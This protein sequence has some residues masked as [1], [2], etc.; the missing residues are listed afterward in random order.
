MA[1]RKELDVAV[2][3]ISKYHTKISILHCVSQYPTEYQ[4]VNLKTIE[5]LKTTTQITQLATLIIPLVLLL[6]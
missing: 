5:F 2:D 4:N 1:G 6:L 3:L